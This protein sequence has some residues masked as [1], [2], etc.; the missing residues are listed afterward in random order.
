MVEDYRVRLL[1]ENQ[2]VVEKSLKVRFLSSFVLLLGRV[3]VRSTTIFYHMI[4]KWNLM[5]TFYENIIV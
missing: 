2:S 1:G 5:N 4:S 3:V